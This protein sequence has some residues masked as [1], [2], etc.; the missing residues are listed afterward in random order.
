M[1]HKLEKSLDFGSFAHEN[2]CP[3]LDA[4][5]RSLDISIASKYWLLTHDKPQVMRELTETE[6]ETNCCQVETTFDSYMRS[7][8]RPRFFNF[9]VQHS[10]MLHLSLVEVLHNFNYLWHL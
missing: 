5:Y 1:T 2:Y 9:E 7:R 10:I 8:S 4:T 3:T 6:R